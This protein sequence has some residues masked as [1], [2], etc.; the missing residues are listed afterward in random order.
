MLRQEMKKIKNEFKEQEMNWKREHEEMRQCIKGL[1][2]KIEE[3]KKTWI[4]IVEKD[5]RR[6]KGQRKHSK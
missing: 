1:E 2:Q 5:E 4:E 3:M 6:E